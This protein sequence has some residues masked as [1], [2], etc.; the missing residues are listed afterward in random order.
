VVTPNRLHRAV[1]AAV[2]A[3]LVAGCAAARGDHTLPQ[4]PQARPGGQAPTI[5]LPLDPYMD[6]PRQRRLLATAHTILARECL[7]RFGLELPASTPAWAMP[8]EGNDDRYGLVDPQQAREHGYHLPEPAWGPSPATPEQSGPQWAV[9]T[10]EG[11]RAHAGRPVP[12]GGCVGEAQRALAG[13]VAAPTDPGLAQ[14]LSVDSY[15]RSRHDPRVR[16]VFGAWSRCMRRAGFGYADPM[17]A[18]DDPAFHTPR[19]SPREVAVATT[20]VR[21]KQAVG[22][23]EVWAAVEAAYQLRALDRHAAQLRVLKRWLDTRLRN[24]ARV[25][26]RLGGDGGR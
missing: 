9:L 2:A 5:V 8:A 23:V 20:D 13:R 10:G 24:A 18:N 14:R 26:A 4:A 19:P 15:G 22:L 6:S 11:A 17:Q 1:L 3:L 12:P 16:A 7:R 21:C 25:A